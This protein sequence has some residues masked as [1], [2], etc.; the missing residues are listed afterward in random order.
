MAV[1]VGA[2]PSSVAVLVVLNPL[3]YARCWIGVFSVAVFHIEVRSSSASG[4]SGGS[5]RGITFG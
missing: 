4:L 1:E 3:R 5:G 2:E